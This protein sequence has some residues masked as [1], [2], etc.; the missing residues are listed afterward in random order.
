MKD[1]RNEALIAL[2]QALA[3]VLNIGLQDLPREAKERVQNLIQR[4]EATVCADVQLI[5]FRL[6]FNL[7]DSTGKIVQ[8]FRIETQPSTKDVH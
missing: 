2:N 5:P 6:Q 3:D 7:K 1:E 8:I 4:R